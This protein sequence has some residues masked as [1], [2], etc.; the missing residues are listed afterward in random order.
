[1]H[2]EQDGV[3]VPRPLEVVVVLDRLGASWTTL[4]LVV[5]SGVLGYVVVLLLTRLTGVR[6]LAKMSSVATLRRE[7]TGDVSVLLVDE[8]LEAELFVGVRGAEALR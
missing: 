8:P 1:M 2:G 4:G 5:L 6:S 7:T 3:A